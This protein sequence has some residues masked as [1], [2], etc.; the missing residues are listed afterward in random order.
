VAKRPDL[1]ELDAPE[2]EELALAKTER[3]KRSRCS[4]PNRKVLQKCKAFSGS[5]GSAYGTRAPARFL[6]TQ[7]L[8]LI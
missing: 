1:N 7:P 8:N 6:Y 4:T 3:I 5:G 2:W